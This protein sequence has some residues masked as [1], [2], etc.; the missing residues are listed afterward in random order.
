VL[1][2]LSNSVFESVRV[3]NEFLTIAKSACL[4]CAYEVSVIVNQYYMR[5]TWPKVT[6]D[7]YNTNLFLSITVTEFFPFS[8]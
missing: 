7:I 5:Y 1:H 3:Q 8:K 2:I 4:Q 6:K